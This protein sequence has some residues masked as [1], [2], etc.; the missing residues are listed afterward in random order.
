MAGLEVNR[1][2]EQ[3]YGL[4]VLQ[5]DWSTGKQVEKITG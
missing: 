1:L 2:A 3:V 4:I 5:V